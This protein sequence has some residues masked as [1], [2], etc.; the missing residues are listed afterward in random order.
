MV[1]RILYHL[2]EVVSFF[3]PTKALA[4]FYNGG[5]IYEGID[6]AGA[7]GGIDNRPPRQVI[8]DIV[9]TALSYAALIAVVVVIIAGFYLILGLGDEG[10]KD[11]AKK[12]I[13]YTGIGL[14]VLLTAK[15]IVGFFISLPQ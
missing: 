6:E 5:G 3:G 4:Q 15:L 11:K 2:S 12:I 13:L 1:T 14:V 10:A 7:V 8:A 9:N